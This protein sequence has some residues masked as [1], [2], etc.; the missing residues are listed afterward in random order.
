MAGIPLGYFGE[1][2]G[3]Y[4]GFVAVCRMAS[5]LIHRGGR[6]DYHVYSPFFFFSPFLPPALQRQN[7]ISNDAVGGKLKG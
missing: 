3:V 1:R 7:L 6:L 2:N 4:F 5:M